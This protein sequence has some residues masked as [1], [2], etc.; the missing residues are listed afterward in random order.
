MW[1]GGGTLVGCVRGW[2]VGGRKL[3]S[4]P[5]RFDD[6]TSHNIIHRLMRSMGG[7]HVPDTREESPKPIDI[8]IANNIQ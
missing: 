7:R 5:P 2:L 6:P 1:D 4:C 8:V 3:V